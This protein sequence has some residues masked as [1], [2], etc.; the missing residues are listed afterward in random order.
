MKT[1]AIGERY[2]HRPGLERS[3]AGWTLVELLV[4]IV[5]IVVLAA[6][7]LALSRRGL[8]SARATTCMSNVKQVGMALL[9]HAGDNS[10]KLIPLQPSENPETGKRPP[11]WTV[12]LA[13]E[14]YLTS[15]NGVGNAPC[16][17]G[18][19]TCPEC[20]FMSHA[21]GG[22]GV[23]EGT[24]FVYQENRPTGVNESGSLRLSRIVDP[25][26]TWLVGDATGS[27]SNPKRGWYAIWSQPGRW[28][29]HGPA[30]R[31]GGKVNVCMVDG[32]V[33]RLTVKEIEN[34]KLT[35]DVLTGRR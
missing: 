16:G 2:S 31:H 8:E 6:A 22:Y 19:W 1:A 14:G 7:V 17:T 32:H 13:R 34:R 9:M 29:N 35:E 28:N 18:V 3:R 5:V 30:A 21:Y 27:A 23:V 20:D 10:N 15:W 24:I 12:Q 26:N 25:A 4:V 11:I 33:E